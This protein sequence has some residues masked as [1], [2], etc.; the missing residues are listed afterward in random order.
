MSHKTDY[1]FIINYPAAFA[2]VA[3]L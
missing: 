3:A 2:Q 1:K